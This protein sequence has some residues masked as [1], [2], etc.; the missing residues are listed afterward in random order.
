MTLFN[1]KTRKELISFNRRSYFELCYNYL[2][3]L[4]VVFQGI[5]KAKL[6]SNF[7]FREKAKRQ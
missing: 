5:I 7:L 3:E 2:L 6:C 4:Q 1:Q